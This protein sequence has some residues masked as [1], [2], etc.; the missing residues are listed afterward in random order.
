MENGVVVNIVLCVG[1]SEWQPAAGSTAV[2][3]P[4]NTVVAIGHTYR[5]A[6]CRRLDS[7]LFVQS[8]DESNVPPHRKP[9]PTDA[10]TAELRAEREF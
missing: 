9:R 7:G 4:E 3:V 1:G 8:L 5:G 10:D 2:A 6:I